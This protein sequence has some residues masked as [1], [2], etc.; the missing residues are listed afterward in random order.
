[1]CLSLYVLLICCTVISV[2]L[3]NNTEVTV[4]RFLFCLQFIVQ[5]YGKTLTKT[6]LSTETIE[7]LCNS[8]TQTICIYPRDILTKYA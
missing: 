4:C 7:I 1:M 3:R 5:C 8:T 2:P 6:V